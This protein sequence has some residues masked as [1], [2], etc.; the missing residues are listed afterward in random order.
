M[1][2]LTQAPENCTIVL[3]FWG[4]E[5]SGRDKIMK[6]SDI[7]VGGFYV[8][9]DGKYI[10]E[11]IDEYEGK[12]EWLSYSLDDGSS[13]GDSG[14][15]EASSIASWAGREATPEEIE[16]LDKTG[17]HQK[18][19]EKK[20]KTYQG[21]KETILPILP[22]NELLAEVYRRGLISKDGRLKLDN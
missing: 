4:K 5:I 2:V 8:K 15:L 12:L 11:I 1:R 3:S 19:R 21:L 14:F 17:A 9:E 16:R 7:K 18:E 20:I 13:W 6:S 10:R 22:N